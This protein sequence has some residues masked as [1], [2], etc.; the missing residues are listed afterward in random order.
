MHTVKFIQIQ[1]E[2]AYIHCIYYYHAVSICFSQIFWSQFNCFF[3]FNDFT[4]KNRFRNAWIFHFGKI[5]F[6]MY[7]FLWIHK[8]I[9]KGKKFNK[10][11]MKI[12]QNRDKIDCIMNI[13]LNNGS[14]QLV[15]YKQR[16]IYFVTKSK[17]ICSLSAETDLVRNS[18]AKKTPLLNTMSVSHCCLENKNAILKQLVIL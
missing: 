10:T 4:Q 5:H 12:I 15:P 16:V 14:D 6:W 11:L 18:T 13:K 3:S 2:N 1:H 17:E 9:K 8:I 7:V